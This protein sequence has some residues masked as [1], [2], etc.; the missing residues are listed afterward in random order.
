MNCERQDELLDA[1]G[2]GYVG[3]ELESHVAACQACGE[4]RRVAGALLD[5]K[6]VAMSEAHVPSS[7][8]MW[9]RMRV[10]HRQEVAARARGSLLV[11]QAATL[12][13]AIALVTWFF[14]ADIAA[15]L[16]HLVTTVRV[17]TP[18]LLAAASLLLLVPVAGWVAIRQK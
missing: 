5:D 12:I 14:G 13:V 10:R 6:V 1:L 16:R 17:S 7:G 3:A 18:L 11:G 15:G 8:T 2:R 9:W 4:L